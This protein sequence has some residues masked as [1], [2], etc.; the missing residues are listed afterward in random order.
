MLKLWSVFSDITGFLV[1][2]GIPAYVFYRQPKSGER[3]LAIRFIVSVLGVW[4]ALALHRYFIDWPVALA[5]AQARGDLDYDGVGANAV[6]FVGGWIFGIITS[7]VA[8]VVFL[9]L[10]YI[11]R[12]QQ[13]KS[14]ASA[15]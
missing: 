14:R 1:L 10:R 4:F 3:N 12:R 9:A 8:L 13:H 7:T 6:I 11:R 2:F 15:P 5:R